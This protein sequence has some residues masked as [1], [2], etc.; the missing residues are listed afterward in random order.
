MYI[1]W[2]QG[3][4]QPGEDVTLLTSLILA[5]ARSVAALDH[6]WAFWRLKHHHFLGA[7]ALHL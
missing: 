4:P 3:F 5:L 1:P 7:E 6:P 2:M